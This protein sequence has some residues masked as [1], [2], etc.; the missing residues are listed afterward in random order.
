MQI[1][2][3][4]KKFQYD[5]NRKNHHRKL[6][7]D[8]RQK[9]LYLESPFKR[10]IIMTDTKSLETKAIRTKDSSDLEA[11]EISGID[12]VDAAN[13]PEQAIPRHTLAAILASFRDAEK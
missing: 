13:Q 1:K 11:E 4:S 10:Q 7:L 3:V 5:L 2:A 12:E 6:A 8:K 9:L